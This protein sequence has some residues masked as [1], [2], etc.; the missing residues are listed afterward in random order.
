VYDSATQQLRELIPL[1]PGHVRV[2]VCGATPQSSPHI[3]HVRSQVSFDVLRRWLQRSGLAVTFV[4]NV[5]DIDDKI[6]AKAA[7]AGRPW[8][9]HAYLYEQEFTAAYDALNVLRPT[10]EPRA[11]G[12]VPDM[13]ELVDRLVAAGHAYPAQDHSGDVYFDV[14]SYAG[15]G[16]LTRQ[17][18]EEMAPAEDADPRGKRDARDFALWKGA[19]PGEPESASWTTPWG[20][21]RPGWHLE[22]SAMAR[23][24]LGAEFDVHGGGLE[25]RFPHHENE[26]AQSCAAGEGF[27]RYWMHNGWVVQAGEKMSK[28]LGNTMTVEALTQR[29]P[30]AVVRY[31]L[32]GPHYRSHIE[33]GPGSLEEAATAYERVAGFVRRVAEL[34]GDAVTGVDLQEVGLPEAFVAAMDDDLGTPAALAV[35]HDTVRSGNASLAARHAGDAAQAAVVVRAMADVLGV[36][37]LDPHWSARHAVEDDRLRAALDAMVHDALQART[38]ARQAK[39]YAAADAIRGRLTAAGIAV[40]DT[41]DGPRWTLS[42]DVV[43]S[44]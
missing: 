1:E 17:N 37:P 29:V 34:C 36:D 14:R 28:S 9:A 11:T 10:Y 12:H 38:A 24:Y 40:E 5:T 22:C 19:K 35:L 7:E 8:W 42:G 13:V 21:G 3:G 23:R 16:A 41:P 31:L 2:Y 30:A 44:P 25:L 20:R 27:A 32:A 33:V 39:D 6:L 4:R 15:Y 18:V 26:R 43:P